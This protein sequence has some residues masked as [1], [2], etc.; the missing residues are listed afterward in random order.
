MFRAWWS[1]PR[2][3]ASEMFAS[4]E[5]LLNARAQ[6]EARMPLTCG[7]LPYPFLRAAS[8]AVLYPQRQQASGENDGGHDLGEDLQD[9]DKGLSGREDVEKGFGYSA[10]GVPT[11]FSNADHETPAVSPSVVTSGL[12][13]EGDMACLMADGGSDTCV[14]GENG[15]NFGWM[16]SMR[17]LSE[18]RAARSPSLSP[19]RSRAA[20]S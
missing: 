14:V 13:L 20:V 18:V 5:T 2:D 16:L 6:K 8:P 15:M 11:L 4:D 7:S 9:I 1:S 12:G 17:C 10:V 3:T 19:G